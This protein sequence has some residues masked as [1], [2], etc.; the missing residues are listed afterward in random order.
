MKE[1]RGSVESWVLSTSIILVG[2]SKGVLSRG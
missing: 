1:E 2:T